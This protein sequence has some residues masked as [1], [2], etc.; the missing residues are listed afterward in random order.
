MKELIDKWQ[1]KLTI[2]TAL[3][4]EETDFEIKNI[5][6]DKEVLIEE[7]IKDLKK[8]KNSNKK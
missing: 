6:S 4:I 7:F 8:W 3:R 5:Y 1:H 2:L